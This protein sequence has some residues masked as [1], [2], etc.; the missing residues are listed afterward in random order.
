[1]LATLRSDNVRKRGRPPITPTKNPNWGTY[2]VRVVGLDG[3]VVKERAFQ[4]ERQRLTWR[5]QVQ[6]QRYVSDQVGVCM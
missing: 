5:R 4:T 1:M 3:A 2:R 6:L